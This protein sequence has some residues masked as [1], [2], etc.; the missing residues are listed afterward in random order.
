MSKLAGFSAA[1]SLFAVLLL[2]NQ[3]SAQT[4]DVTGS[5]TGSGNV[6]MFNSQQV[7]C[8]VSFSGSNNSTSGD[9]NDPATFTAGSFFCGLIVSPSGD[10]KFEVIPGVYDK[11]RVYIGANVI[12]GGSCYGPVEADWNN[13]TSTIS[14]NNNAIPGSTC[15]VVSGSVQISA[16]RKL[17]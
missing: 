6:T 10:W 5:F 3:A 13:A 7:T 17:V 1:A 16:P 14:F 9:I 2:S 8:N 11:L 12:G 4:F 15:V